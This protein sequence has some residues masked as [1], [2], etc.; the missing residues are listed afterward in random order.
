M[1][2]SRQTHF[3]YPLSWAKASKYPLVLPELA[4]AV[5][6]I[7]AWHRR[8]RFQELQ[9]ASNGRRNKKFDS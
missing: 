4:A 8:D 1:E 7:W 9:A 2:D 6:V 3:C 5:V